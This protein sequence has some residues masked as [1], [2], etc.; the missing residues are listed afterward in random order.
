MTIQPAGV[1]SDNDH[2]YVLKSDLE[3]TPTAQL[4]TITK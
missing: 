1:A 4:K 2:R 3:I